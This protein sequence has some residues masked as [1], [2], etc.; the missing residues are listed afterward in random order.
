MFCSLI[1]GAD[2]L[3]KDWVSTKIGNPNF[4]LCV[5]IGVMSET[6]IIAGI[7]YHNFI[8]SPDGRPISIEISM[9]AINQRWANRRTLKALFEYPFNQLGVE[10]VQVTTP[11]ESKHVRKIN[12]KLGFTYEGTGRK[13][14][15]LGGDVDVLS[16]LRHECHWIK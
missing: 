8:R 12:E 11:V 13:A 5:A 2:D 15:F 9:A 14:H 3:I 1:Y 6:E 10:R 7:V 4:G 16:M